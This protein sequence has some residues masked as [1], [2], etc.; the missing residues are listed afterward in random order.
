MTFD[1]LL[2]LVP[3]M[4]IGR[5]QIHLLPLVAS[6][7]GDWLGTHRSSFAHDRLLCRLI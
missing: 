1:S 3:T 2:K 5:P 4:G 6:I 7:I